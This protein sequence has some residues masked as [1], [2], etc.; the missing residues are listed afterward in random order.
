MCILNN[1]RIKTELLIVF[2][3]REGKTTIFGFS[4]SVHGAVL[5]PQHQFNHKAGAK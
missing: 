1:D 4:F 2:L 5:I 3:N